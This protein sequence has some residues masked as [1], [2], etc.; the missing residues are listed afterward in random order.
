MPP[1]TASVRAAPPCT[2]VVGPVAVDADHAPLDAP[3]RADHAA[4]LDDGIAHRPPMAVGGQRAA[5]AEPARNGAVGPW[6]ERD[7]ADLVE[8]R[9]LQVGIPEPAFLGRKPLLNGAERPG[10]VAG[11]QLGRRSAGRTDR[12]S[13]RTNSPPPA[14]AAADAAAISAAAERRTSA[15][16][17]F[18]CARTLTRSSLSANPSRHA[19]FSEA[20]FTT[21]FTRLW[22]VDHNF[23]TGKTGA[24]AGDPAPRLLTCRT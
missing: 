20:H 12:S 11:R 13:S 22:R 15:C 17:S 1:A 7:L 6:P 2:R 21:G 16:A 3:G 18:S 10:V 5:A 4:V 24:N 14:G 9:D 19:A 8:V 23:S